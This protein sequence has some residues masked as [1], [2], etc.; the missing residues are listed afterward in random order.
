M[1]NTKPEDLKTIFVIMY[2]HH[3]LVFTDQQ[4][5]ASYLSTLRQNPDTCKHLHGVVETIPN[6]N[7]YESNLLLSLQGK[8]LLKVG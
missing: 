6:L 8:E 3:P 4:A 5:Y 7:I 1:V 2:D